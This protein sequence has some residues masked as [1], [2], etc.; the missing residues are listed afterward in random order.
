MYLDEGGLVMKNGTNFPIDPGDMHA[1]KRWLAQHEDQSMLRQVGIEEILIGTDVLFQLP[2][3]L[4]RAGIVS[5]SRVLLVG[6]FQ[7]VE[8]GAHV[9]LAEGSQRLLALLALRGRPVKFREG[10]T[11][12]TFTVAESDRDPVDTVI[13]LELTGPAAAIAP[14]DIAPAASAP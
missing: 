12:W 11:N 2:L 3:V 4:Q 9:A 6:G 5:G 14:V 13:Q 1:L 8:G 7:M 10:P